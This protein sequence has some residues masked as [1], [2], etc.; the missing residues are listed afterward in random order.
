MNE[1]AIGRWTG[2][3]A[4]G[5]WLRRRGTV[6]LILL[7]PV[8]AV[9]SVYILSDSGQAQTSPVVT[10]I[11]LLLDLCYILMLAALI[12][13]RIGTLVV[14]RRKRSAGTRLHLRLAGVFAM[15]ALVPTIIVAVFATLT[16]GIGLES[17]FSDRIGSV[18]R[19]SLATAEAY[20]REHRTGLRTDALNMA[21]DLNR[22]ARQ[23]ISQVQLGEL[24]VQQALVRELPRA[25]VFNLD[26]EILARGEFSYL[27]NFTPP[28][29]EQLQAAR[30]GEL[31]IVAD[32]DRNEMRALVYLA[33]YFD[34]FLYISRTVQGDV[35]RLLDETRGTVQFY[36]RLEG[37]RG[38]V[39]FDYALIYLG[40]ALF[41]ILSA[42][43][44][45]LWFAERLAKPVGRLAGAAEQVGA[46]DLDVRV[47]EERGNDEIAVLSRVFN[48]MTGQLKGQRDDLIRARDETERR[49]QFI[50]AV[51]S[52]VTAGVVGLDG[53]GRIDLMNEAAAE[54]LGLDL[55]DCLGKSLEDFAPGMAEL[56]GQACT[57][58]N[59][60]AS[61]EVHHPVRGE[62]REFLARV[63][64]KLADD[65][66]E[67][68][69]LT[70]DDMTALASA[71][72]MAAWGDVARRIAH[73][74]KNPL[75]P[76]QLS[77]DRMRRKI[78]KQFREEGES[79]D[80][81]LDVIT[82]QA[83]DIRRMVDEFSKF[84]RMPEP[85]L[86]PRDLA[87][88]V[89]EA[90]LLQ[91]EARGDIDYRLELDGSE[92]PVTVDRGLINQ[93]LVNLLQN[94]ADAIDGRVERDGEDAPAPAI[95]IQIEEGV[96]FWRLCI[97]D[98]GVGLP[99]EGRDKLTDPYVTTRAKGTGLGLAIVKKIVQQHGGDVQLGDADGVDGLDGAS[100]IVRLPKQA[101]KSTGTGA[102]EAA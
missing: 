21:G 45:G 89:R 62:E 97:N 77:A 101:A 72:R 36:E 47:K 6:L 102:G 49:R 2:L 20:E 54:M 44:L 43:M 22:A 17:L 100:V 41:V 5:S 79:F 28:T 32:P 57:A 94:A 87:A 13:W 83:G 14:G 48:R 90:V 86:E 8:L 18:V 35:L 31:V 82:R 3:S 50:E 64:P 85:T 55:Q 16:L 37:E 76:I 96:R 40:F 92:V 34:A 63:A 9:L 98:N 1:Q 78:A 75:T 81:Y 67:G 71:Q 27:F 24:V 91:K 65:P 73:E 69:V 4:A 7:G 33:N 70:F 53:E 30:R 84:A 99:G 26:K 11:V 10:R 58:A 42:I 68:F 39:M 51:L 56:H 52:G 23:G 46:G 74:I 29:D 93:L 60:V 80:Q 59:A 66:G 19:N 15:V 88:L 12:A 61:G 95:E 38:S 25:Y